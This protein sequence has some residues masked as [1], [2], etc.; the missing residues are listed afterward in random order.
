MYKITPARGEFPETKTLLPP[1]DPESSLNIGEYGIWKVTLKKTE[2]DFDFNEHG[3]KKNDSYKENVKTPLLEGQSTDVTQT[4]YE[5]NLKARKECIE[6]Y[7]SICA[8]CLFNFKKIYGDVG[9]GFIHVHHITPI[10]SKGAEY[11]VNPIED[12]IPLCP[13]C[14]AMIH[15]TNPPFTI[16]Q[17]KTIYQRYKQ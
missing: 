12:L 8:V 11:I 14:H 4:K 5:R 15:R 7:G 9:E 13:N 2:G 17:M 1:C 3:F 6:H 16:N 10:S